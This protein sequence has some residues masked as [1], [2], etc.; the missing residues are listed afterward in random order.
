M[1]LW[2][3]KIQKDNAKEDKKLCEN[4]LNRKHNDIVYSLWY[5]FDLFDVKNKF[6]LKYRGR[7]TSSIYGWV[8]QLKTFDKFNIEHTIYF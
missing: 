2:R 7:E 8:E 1:E 3:K 5:S 4:L 6:A